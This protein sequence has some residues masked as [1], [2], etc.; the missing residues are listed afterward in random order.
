MHPKS[1][2]K[3]HEQA[4]VFLFNFA[5]KIVT[6]D[7]ASNL[8]VHFVRSSFNSTM[9]CIICNAVP[10]APGNSFLC[11]LCNSFAWG[12]NRTAEVTLFLEGPPAAL[13]KVMNACKRRDPIMKVPRDL[14]ILDSQRWSNGSNDNSH[15]GEIHCVAKDVSEL[16]KAIEA[17]GIRVQECLH[18]YID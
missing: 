1:S 13:T 2:S 8:P 5:K 17:H 6:I 9:S 16:R 3:S 7:L 12:K 18:G 11:T 14:H 4:M 10:L 15:R